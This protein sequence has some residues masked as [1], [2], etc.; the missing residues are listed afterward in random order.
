MDPQKLSRTHQHE[1]GDLSPL[2]LGSMFKYDATELVALWLAISEINSWSTFGEVDLLDASRSSIALDKF[3]A[4]DEL[5]QEP[6]D[7]V[8]R[9]H[10]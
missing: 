9:L 7:Q 10:D 4:P 3:D 6:R 2:K 1:K 8:A 5:G